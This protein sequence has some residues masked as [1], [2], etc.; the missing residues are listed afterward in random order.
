MTE[1]SRIPQAA[2]AP[3]TKDDASA[4]R[5]RKI[6]SCAMSVRASLVLFALNTDRNAL[7]RQADAARLFH[8][9]PPEALPATRRRLLDE[10][11]A[12]V[13]AVIVYGLGHRAPNSVVVEYL[14]TTRAL[15]EDQG[16]SPEATEAFI[17]GPFHVYMERLMEEK[18]KECPVIFLRRLYGL[19]ETQ[20]IPAHPLAVFSGLMA[21]LICAVIDKL[22]QYDMR[23]E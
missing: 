20:P 19:D 12:F 8:N 22:D 11:R 9:V 17:D 14:R 13:H 2:P 21:M 18:H 5:P 23:P 16:Y 10:W 15:L 3:Q 1:Q 7:L 6:L 4:Q